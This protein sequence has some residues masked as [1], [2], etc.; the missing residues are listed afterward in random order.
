MHPP[1]TPPDL[2]L[3]PWR[4]WRQQA[5]SL[6]PESAQ[7]QSTEWLLELGLRALGTFRTQ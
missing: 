4:P 7:L 2:L 1:P 5:R 3:T 6:S